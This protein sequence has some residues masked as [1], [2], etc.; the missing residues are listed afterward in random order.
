MAKR[1][2]IVGSGDV[3]G[4]LACELAADGHKVWG[5]RR[6]NKP[7]GDGVTTIS[8]DVAD[9]ETLMDLPAELDY[10]VYAVASPDFSEEGYQ[11]FYVQG[12]KNIL[13]LLKAGGNKIKHVFFVSSSSVYHHH[14]GS[15]VNEDTLC[16]PTSFAGKKMLEAEQV[17][18]NG[19]FPGTAV[20]FSGIYGPGRT[21]LISQ[22]KSGGHCDPEPPV[23]TNRIH[24]DDCVAVLKFLI[25][26]DITGSKL[27]KIYLASDPSPTPLF[28]VLEWMKDRIGD[29]A[30][31]KDLPE[32]TR[33]GS[34]QCSCQRLLDLGYE[35][36]YPNYQVG[37]EEILQD[38][39]Y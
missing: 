22:A 20:R 17:L 16:E 25:E 3:G 13:A 21:R 34:K 14:D 4:H 38:M 30:D 12:L 19:P 28:D 6:S 33:R 15:V 5:L 37:Y 24:R 32:A 26:K 10:L 18:F 36:I 1:I 29:V 7:V 31:D 23:W 2:L 9:P 8:A 11:Q 39:G 35:F 27:D